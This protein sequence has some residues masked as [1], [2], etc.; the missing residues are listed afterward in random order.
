M[1]A[2]SRV[3]RFGEVV[4]HATNEDGAVCDKR[5][6]GLRYS[7]RKDKQISGRLALTGGPGRVHAPEKATGRDTPGL[8]V[9]KGV[10]PET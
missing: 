7:W 1:P 3:G 10:F 8:L 6:D 4:L 2:L 5:H 9:E